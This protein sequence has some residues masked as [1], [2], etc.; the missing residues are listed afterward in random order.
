M[1]MGVGGWLYPRDFLHHTDQ[2]RGFSAT[3]R[4]ISGPQGWVCTIGSDASA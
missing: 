4:G 3:Y 2:A 1:Y